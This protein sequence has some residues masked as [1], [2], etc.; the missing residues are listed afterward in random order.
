M[1]LLSIAVV[2]G[3]LVAM[4]S[5]KIPPTLALATAIAIAGIFQLA[6]PEELFAGLSNGG[7]I[8]VA[9]ML[10]IAKGVIHTGV[11][12]RVT[13]RL[14]KTVTSATQVLLRLIAPIGLFSAMINTTPI[15]AMLIPAARELQQT[16]QIP[17]R[18]VLLPMAHATTL[19]GSTTLIG[20]SSN[21]LIAGIATSAG[22]AVG[23]FSFAPV[24]VP[25]MLVGWAVLLVTAP[26]MFKAGD[27]L[28][29]P[30]PEWRVEIS[31]DD[32]AL[33]IGRTAAD[34]GLDSA[35]DY[36]LEGISRDRVMHGPEEVIQDGDRLV[37]SATEKGVRSLWSSPRLG[38]DASR[39]YLATV[40]S[41]EHGLLRELADEDELVVVAAQTDSALRDTRAVPGELCFLTTHKPRLI[42]DNSSFSLATDVTGKAPQPQKTW[43]ALL[44]LVLVVVAAAA[45]LAPI[46]IVA[47]AGAV[48]MVWARV[49]TPRAAVRALDWNV[50]MI[51][52]GSVGLAAI[53]VSSGIADW[54]AQTIQD[55]SAGSVPLVVIVLAVSTTILTNVTTNAAAASIL[56]PVGITLAE[57]QGLS[58]VLILA[59]IGTAISFTFINPFSHQSNL[60]VMGPGKYSIRSFVR[61]GIPLT[62]ASVLALCAV[63]Y[64]LL[65]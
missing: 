54:I 61:F 34:L 20:T 26:R 47:I 52:A 58:P 18:Q 4:A 23:M 5:G 14:L 10:V 55:I 22:V 11:V 3:T 24:A 17:A 31:L 13:W 59:M 45:N 25:V 30:D 38:L 21:L 9:A 64:L 1:L 57:S 19:A 28:D 51:L 33:A 6:P 46:P 56:T 12:S 35:L 27:E 36:Q 15:V 7:V 63:G 50:L 2:V 49:L 41:G 39:L 44:I 40:A 29:V 62:I 43:P 16:R 65:A 32:Q 53:V 8:T 48:A 42:D 37:F 60:M